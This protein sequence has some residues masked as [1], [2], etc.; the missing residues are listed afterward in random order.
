METNNNQ[1]AFLIDTTRCIGC[2]GCQVACKQ[3]NELPAEKTEFFGGPGYQNPAH[4]SATT[5]TLINYH[6]VTENG[7]LKDWVFRKDQCQHCLEPACASACL[8]GAL[9]KTENGP[10]IWDS[11]KCIGCRYCMISCPF[12]VP[13]FEWYD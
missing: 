11:S 8:V 12:D 13:K 3:W 2:R 1:K 10:V 4:M 9:H 7:E 6:E 5:F